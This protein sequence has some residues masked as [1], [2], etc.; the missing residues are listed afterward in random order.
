MLFEDV[1]SI[2]HD[3]PSMEGHFPDDPQVPHAV[4]LDRLLALVADRSKRRVSEVVAM[5]FHHTVRSGVPYRVYAVD[6]APGQMGLR[7][8]AGPD[9]LLDAEFKWTPLEEGFGG[10]GPE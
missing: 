2:P 8:M 5:E 10:G 4:L 9:D 6:G 7:V 1:V 3:H